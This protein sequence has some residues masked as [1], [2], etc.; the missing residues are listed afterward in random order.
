M[1]TTNTEFTE[2]KVVNEFRRS[3]GDA[4]RIGTREFKGR[5]YFE[6]RQWFQDNKSQKMIPT[7]K[8][9]IL[10]INELPTLMSGLCEV[11]EGAGVSVDNK[12]KS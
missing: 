2:S 10:N 11:A 8:G 4:V 9:I 7:K 12:A 1:P 3:N 5:K 6:I